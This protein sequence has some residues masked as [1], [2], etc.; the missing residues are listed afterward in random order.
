MG[1]AAGRAS[2]EIEHPMVTARIQAIFFIRGTMMVLAE[3]DVNN[4]K[5]SNWLI[6]A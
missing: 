3:V 5:Y 1:C 6:A 4:I 2:L